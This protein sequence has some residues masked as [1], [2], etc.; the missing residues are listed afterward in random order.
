[1]YLTDILTLPANIA[2]IPGIPVPSGVVD[3]MPVGFEILAAP[4]H[5]ETMLR[6]AHAY[7]QGHRLRPHL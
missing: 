2:G 1:M 3:G 5:E 6:V 4:L 7:E